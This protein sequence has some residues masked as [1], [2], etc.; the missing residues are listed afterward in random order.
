MLDG[1]D[2]IETVSIAG[3]RCTSLNQTVNDMLRDYEMIDELSFVQALADYYYGNGESF[4]GLQIAPQY[5][6][7]LIPS[8][9]G[10]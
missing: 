3:S 6:D 10:R 5:A 9:I 7:R 2:E 4:D 1:F 8:R